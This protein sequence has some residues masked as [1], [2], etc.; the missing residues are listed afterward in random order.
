[1]SGRALLVQGEL[2]LWRDPKTWSTTQHNNM[3]LSS[4]S[5]DG[6]WTGSLL[7]SF[8]LAGGGT[9]VGGGEAWWPLGKTVNRPRILWVPNASDVTVANI[10]LVDSPAWNLGLRGDHILIDS[11]RVES[12]LSS[13]GGYGHSPNTDG[14]NVGGHNITVRNFWVHNGDDCVPIT[15]GNDGSTRGVLVEN[16]HC[17]CG[18]NGVVVYNQGGVVANVIARNVTVKGTNQGAGVKLSEPRRDATGGLVENVT[19]GPDYHI[20]HPR[21]AALYI[22]VFQEDAQPPCVLPAKPDRPKWLTVHNLTFVAL[23]ASVIDGQAAGCFRCTPGLPCDANFYSVSVT[24]DSGAP[25]PDFICHN[26]RGSVGGAG[27]VPSACK[28]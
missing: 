25:A 18:T 21:Y 20:L 17:E 22:N 4:T 7:E 12:G 10:T 6:A 3:F 23:T 8:T 13:C 14:A 5:Y 19:F 11:V 16:A 28:R 27:S 24:L 26:V 1:M 9:I 15:T 2:H